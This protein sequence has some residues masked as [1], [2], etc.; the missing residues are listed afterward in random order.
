MHS[1]VC[2]YVAL[3]FIGS[4][5]SYHLQTQTTKNIQNFNC[6]LFYIVTDNKTM[7]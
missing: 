5:P 1:H 6:F 3:S 2:E 4:S 7:S